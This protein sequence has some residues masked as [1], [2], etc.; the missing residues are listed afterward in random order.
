MR[1]IVWTADHPFA[2]QEIGGEIEVEDDATEDDI[3]Q[4]VA[5]EFHNHFNYGWSEKS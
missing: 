4:L 1:T 5:E 3:D 2:G